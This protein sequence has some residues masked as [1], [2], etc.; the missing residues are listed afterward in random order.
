MRRINYRL[1]NA[2][3]LMVLFAFHSFSLCVIILMTVF[4][5]V[6]YFNHVAH[7]IK[8]MQV[9]MNWRLC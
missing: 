6:C 7:G 1:L 3:Y 5:F 2:D 9:Q 4:E 8:I